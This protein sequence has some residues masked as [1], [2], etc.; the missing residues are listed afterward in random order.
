MVFLFK[1]KTLLKS[2]FEYHFEP[3]LFEIGYKFETGLF[4]K[5]TLKNALLGKNCPFRSNKEKEMETRKSPFS[6]Q[7]QNILFSQ[8]Q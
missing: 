8:I 4:G 5:I 7:A 3:N 6:S 2:S 1:N